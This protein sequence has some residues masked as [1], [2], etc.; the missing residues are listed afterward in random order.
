MLIFGYTLEMIGNVSNE[1][2]T[3]LCFSGFPP[4]P[5]SVQAKILPKASKTLQ[6]NKIQPL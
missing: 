2:G 4:S 5:T 6:N 3:Y 1:K